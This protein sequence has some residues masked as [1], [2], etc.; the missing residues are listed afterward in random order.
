MARNSRI[1]QR[2]IS[3]GFRLLQADLARLPGVER[4]SV[5][6]VLAAE[7]AKPLRGGNRELDSNSLFGDGHRQTDLFRRT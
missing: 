5:K 2:N 1:K 3:L 6:D 7:A 4:E